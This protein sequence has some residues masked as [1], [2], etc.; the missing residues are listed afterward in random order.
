[1]DG[2]IHRKLWQAA[3]AIAGACSLVACSYG[4]PINDSGFESSAVSPD[5]KTLV[6]AYH[7]LNYRPAEG[8][9]AFPDGGV[10]QYDRDRIVLAISGASGS[11]MRVLRAFPADGMPGSGHIAV[12]AQPSDPQHMLV[13]LTDQTST[14]ALPR[15]RRWRLNLAD[16]G[17]EPFPDVERELAMVGRRLGA[18]EFGD[19]RLAAPDGSLLLG[20]N[21]ADGDQLWLRTAAGRLRPLERLTHFYG[22]VDDEVYLWSGDN[23]LVQNWRTGARRVVARA[24]PVTQVTSTLIRDDPTVAAIERAN[25][26]PGPRALIAPDRQTISVDGAMA[27]LDL[28][29]LIR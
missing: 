28:T 26:A 9:A 10:P 18:R 27:H 21:G 11:D 16:G 29:A 5:G 19:V 22:Q 4:A 12:R 24:D 1:M 3:S 23:G 20:V 6:V 25:R 17:L 7:Q 15:V 2:S 8:F 13:I 14:R